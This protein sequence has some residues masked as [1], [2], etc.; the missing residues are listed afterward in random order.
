M[1]KEYKYWVSIWAKFRQDEIVR[2]SGNYKIHKDFLLEKNENEI[3]TAFTQI[4]SLFVN[5]LG[6]IAESPEE[7]GMPLYEKERFRQFSQEWRDSGQAPYRPFVLLYNL[8]TS[9]YIHNNSVYVSN[10]K[11]RN[12]KPLPKYL[13]GI[14]LKVKNQHLLFNKL[15]DYGFYFE[16]LK[17][18]KVTGKDIIINYPDNTILLYL[19]KMLADKAGNTKHLMDFLC[20]SFR[21]L[22]DDMYTTNY[23]CIEDMVDKVHTESEKNFVYKMDEVLMSMNFFRKLYGGYEG[24]GLAY[25]HSEKIMESKGPYSFRMISRS[26]D[27]TDLSIEKML[28]GLRIRNVSN[29]L[30]YIKTC[31]DTIKQIFTEK[32]DIGCEKRRNNICKHGISFNIDDKEYWRCGCC[33][34]AFNFKPKIENIPYYIKLVELG[35]K[36]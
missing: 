12:I 19:F 15:T 23:G 36:K 33:H 8:F 17:N 21:L 26:P 35:E 16:G 6:D 30:E 5:I 34:T 20:C 32:N 14:D 1:L 9:G 10:E 25:Y 7:F 13:S 2:I 31:P 11:Y 28:L 3:R 18:A 27:I 29:C 22:Q 4:N 24:P